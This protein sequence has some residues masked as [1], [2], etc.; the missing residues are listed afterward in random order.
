M[1]F[2]VLSDIHGDILCCKKALEIFEKSD[3]NVLLILGDILYHG[4][5]NDLPHHYKPKEVISTLNPLSEKIIAV[6]VNCDG[7]VD[8]MVLDFPILSISNQLYMNERKIFMSHGHTITPQSLPPLPNGSIFLSGHTH[9][10]TAYKKD[11]VYY[12]NPGS[13]SLPKENFNPSYG[14]LSDTD[15]TVYDLNNNSIILTVNFD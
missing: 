12:C 1:K 14:I 7:E 10:P 5:R 3:C 13:I 9:I 11:K 15:F 6:K 8:Q 2:F 4:P